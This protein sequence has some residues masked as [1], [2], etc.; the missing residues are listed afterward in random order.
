MKTP[1]QS[2]VTYPGK[3]RSKRV[4]FF[5]FSRILKSSVMKASKYNVDDNNFIDD[6]GEAD[7]KTISKST[8]A[9]RMQLNSVGTF[10]R[11]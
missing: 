8:P 2:R 4:F 5:F 7:M 1:D 3:P 11:N 10:S 6:D 9:D